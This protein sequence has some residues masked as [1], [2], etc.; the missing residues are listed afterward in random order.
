MFEFLKTIS[1][2][3]PTASCGPEKPAVSMRE[4]AL[5][6]RHLPA[7]LKLTF[8]RP[9][10]ALD[11]VARRLSQLQWIQEPLGSENK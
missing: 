10:L 2:K 8:T 11:H 6:L 4:R 1:A 3:N 7:F 9:G 5:A